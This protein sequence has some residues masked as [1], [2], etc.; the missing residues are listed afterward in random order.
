MTGQI[1]HC[2]SNSITTQP[3]KLWSVVSSLKERGKKTS[4]GKETVE[5]LLHTPYTYLWL[6]SVLEE[7]SV[8][9]KKSLF[10]RLAVVCLSCSRCWSFGRLLSLLPI[11]PLCDL[12]S[13]KGWAAVTRSWGD[14]FP[15]SWRE[16]E[17]GWCFL[18]FSPSSRSLHPFCQ[19]N[20]DL[21]TTT[22][23]QPP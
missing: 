8:L 2:L 9:L 3:F 17:P 15:A 20:W 10:D 19:G 18:S 13:W 5:P 12:S 22:P 6:G 23:I 21:K 1:N 11:S 7:E 16:T 14:V 4:S